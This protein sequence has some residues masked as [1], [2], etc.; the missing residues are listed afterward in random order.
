M[1]RQQIQELAY[2]LWEQEG[3]PDGRDVDHWL[4]AQAAALAPAP[5]P[6]PAPTTAPKPRPVRRPAIR[7][8]AVKE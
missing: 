5:A 1:D 2:E 3:H 7:A 4:Q 8:S 6:S